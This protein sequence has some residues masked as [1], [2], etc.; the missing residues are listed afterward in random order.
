MVHLK[1]AYV[2]IFKNFYV[3]IYNFYKYILSRFLDYQVSDSKISIY[4]VCNFVNTVYI[5]ILK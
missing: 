3:V 5:Y 2:Y 4:Y 1:I